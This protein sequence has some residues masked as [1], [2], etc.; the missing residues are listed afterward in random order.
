MHIATRIKNLFLTIFAIVRR[1][2]CCFSR[3]RKP[4]YSDC[5][6][7]TSVDVVHANNYRHRNEV[8]EFR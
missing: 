2:L 5:E 8:C 6:V 7:L 4:S 1:G 3:Q